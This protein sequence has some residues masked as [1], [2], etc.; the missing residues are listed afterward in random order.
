MTKPNQLFRFDPTEV[1]P[2]SLHWWERTNL[3]LVERF[4]TS[5]ADKEQNKLGAMYVLMAM[6]HVS[7]DAA[8]AMPWLLVE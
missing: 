4:L 7:S 8:E 3:A 6:T 1:P 2:K 5:V